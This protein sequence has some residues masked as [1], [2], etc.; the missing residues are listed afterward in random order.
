[1][2]EIFERTASPSWANIT[3]LA[4]VNLIVKHNGLKN[5]FFFEVICT[6]VET[7]WD[8]MCPGKLRRGKWRYC[9]LAWNRGG[10]G[11]G[12]LYL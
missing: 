6:F 11:W 1:M 10:G 8:R 5:S 3:R 9:F 2:E 7:Y 4:M 12:G